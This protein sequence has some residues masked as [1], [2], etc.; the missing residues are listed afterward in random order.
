MSSPTILPRSI[1][2]LADG[3]GH[4]FPPAAERSALTGATAAPKR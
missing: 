4:T 3:P 1:P 2:P